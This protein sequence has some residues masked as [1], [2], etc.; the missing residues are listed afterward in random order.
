MKFQHDHIHLTTQN[1]DDWVN[2][3]IEAFGATIVSTVESFGVKMVNIDAGGAKF[4]I[5]NMTGV[6]KLLSSQTGKDVRPPE[7]YHHFGYLVDD[8][9]AC[10]AEFVKKGA[11][12][13]VPAGNASPTLRCGFLKLPGDVRVEVC[14]KLA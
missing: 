7:G 9:D 13:E 12:V 5:S 2:Y 4:R 8:V 1:V 3:Y 14:Q 10:I 6:E 11:T